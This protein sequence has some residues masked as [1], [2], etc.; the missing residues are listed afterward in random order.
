VDKM[1][2]LLPPEILEDAIEQSRA[3]RY[4]LGSTTKYAS[5]EKK[6]SLGQW[7]DATVCRYQV[8]IDHQTPG[9][10]VRTR[11]LAA[12][13]TTFDRE[14]NAIYLLGCEEDRDNPGTWTWPLQ[15]KL[16]RVHAVRPVGLPN[17]PLSAIWHHHRVRRAAGPGPERLDIAHLFSD[18]VGSFFR[19]GQPTIRLEVLVH[20][21]GWMAWCTERP[22]HPKQRVT[23]ETDAGGNPVLRLVVDRCDEEEIASRLLRLGGEFTVVSPPSLV[24]QLR[25]TAAAIVRRHA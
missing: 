25:A 7:H 24:E 8:E 18:S 3:W 20:S 14:E 2:A 16:D 15:W 5:P 10:P 4:S 12:L 6:Q 11:R 21:P 22:F 13:G 9:K 23:R 17:P 1:T 19:Y